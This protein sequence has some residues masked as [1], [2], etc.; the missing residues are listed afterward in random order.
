MFVLFMVIFSLLKVLMVVLISVLFSDLLVILFVSIMILVSVFI[1]F[2]VFL[3]VVLL[4]FE[5][6][7]FVFWLVRFSD[8][9]WLKL[10]FVL[11]IN[12]ICFEKLS[13]VFMVIF[14]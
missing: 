5:R 1:F 4:M 9:K 13:R 10:L 3:R 11:V 12:I 14:Y 7:S 2:F 8:N 6:M